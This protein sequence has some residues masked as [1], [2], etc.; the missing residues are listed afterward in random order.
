VDAGGAG[1]RFLS[2]V[3]ASL[4]SPKRVNLLGVPLDCTTS[5]RPGTRFG[6]QSIR[7]YSDGLE[8]YS[9]VLKADIE[10][11]FI[12]DLGDLPL[13]HGG[14]SRSLEMIEAAVASLY[15]NPS[16]RVVI[17]GGEH[18]LTLPVVSALIK[19]WPHLRL[20]QIDAHFDLREEYE[21][22]RF[23]HATV[24]NHVS[25]L[26]QP[27]ALFQVGM[28]SGTKEEFALARQFS[29]SAPFSIAEIEEVV[30]IIGDH[31]C[32]LSLDL[33]VV[34]PGFLPGTGAPEPGG[35]T[36]GEL[37]AIFEKLKCLNLVGC[38][39]VEL[40][41]PYDPTGASSLLAAKVVR[42]LLLTLSLGGESV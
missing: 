33:D 3:D 9:P 25:G 28:R 31:P 2:T 12:G 8:S 7:L 16:R 24:M 13:P 26:I 40:S 23:S 29:E 17:V 42:E 37:L 6:P 36:S 19:T 30:K 41:P 15:S 21:G 5:F 35:V 14:L 1:V 4:E 38:D 34:D 11:F 22:E 27:G 20:L 10:D 32:Y 39:V 18:L